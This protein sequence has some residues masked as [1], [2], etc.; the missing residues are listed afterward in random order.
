[1]VRV[2]IWNRSVHLAQVSLLHTTQMTKRTSFESAKEISTLAEKQQRKDLWQV[3]AHSSTRYQASLAHRVCVKWS[4][5]KSARHKMILKGCAQA[6][7]RVSSSGLISKIRQAQKAQTCNWLNVAQSNQTKRAHLLSSR[8]LTVAT[9]AQS[10]A[11]SS[12]LR[13]I[14]SLRSHWQDGWTQISLNRARTLAT[15][16]IREVS[17]TQTLLQ[18]TSLWPV[19]TARITQVSKMPWFQAKSTCSQRLRTQSLRQSKTRAILVPPAKARESQEKNKRVL[20][21]TK[22]SKLQHKTSIVG[23]G[24]HQLPERVPQMSGVIQTLCQLMRLQKLSIQETRDKTTSAAISSQ[25]ANSTSCRSLHKKNR[26]SQ[27]T[28]QVNPSIELVHLKLQ[29]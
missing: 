23:E 26:R 8:L 11:R 3:L 13:R 29:R 25:R 27:V 4:P 12:A 7:P 18:R 17:S 24:P 10:W 20:S 1:M 2:T 16:I 28:Y 6:P 21:Q 14:C 22:Y 9:L 19:R 5:H 15:R